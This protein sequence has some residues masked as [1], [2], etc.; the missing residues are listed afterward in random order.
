MLSDADTEIMAS[1]VTASVSNRIPRVATLLQWIMLAAVSLLTMAEIDRLISDAIGPDRQSHSL[2]SVIGPLAIFNVPAWG[3]W[4]SSGLGSTIGWWIVASALIDAL[5]VLAYA[6]ILFRLTARALPPNPP[7]GSPPPLEWVNVSRVLLWSLIATEI[8]EAGFLLFGASVILGLPFPLDVVGGMVAVVSTLKWIVVA[9]FSAAVL[10]NSGTRTILARII[11]HSA[12]AVWVHRLSAVLVLVLVVFSCIPGAGVLDQLPDIQRQWLDSLSGLWYVAVAAAFLGIAAFGSFVLGRQRARCSFDIR[13]RQ[14]EDTAKL[15]FAR[16]W[17]WWLIPVM[18]WAA[19]AVWT[20][21]STV[22]LGGGWSQVPHH[23]GVAAVLFLLVPVMIVLLS[24]WLDGRRDLLSRRTDPDNERA[25]YSWIFGDVLAVLV[26]CVGGLGLVR[27][28]AGFIFLGPFSGLPLLQFVLGVAGFV[29]GVAGAILWP[30]ALVTANSASQTDDATAFWQR[31]TDWPRRHINRTRSYNPVANRSPEE[32]AR[33][34]V[35]LFWLLV[36]GAAVVTAALIF[37]TDFA[38]ALGGVAVTV[39]LIT[40]WGLILGSFTIALQDYRLLAIFRMFRLRAAPVLTLAIVV[41]LVFTVVTASG[42]GDATV[43]ATRLINDAGGTSDTNST[44][45]TNL[46][47]ILRERIT[48]SSC[49]VKTSEGVIVKPIVVVAAQG[50]GIRAAY[51]TSKAMSSLWATKESCLPESVLLSSGVSG[52]SLGLALTKAYKSQAAEKVELLASPSIVASAATGLLAGDLVATGFG[53]H[54]PSM[55]GGDYKWRDRAALIEEGWIKAAKELGKPLD[56]KPTDGTGYLVLNSTDARSKCR[57]LVGQLPASAPNPKQNQSD[58]LSCSSPTIAPAKSGNLA[59]IYGAACPKSLD[60]AAAAMLSAR[61]PFITPAGRFPSGDSSCAKGTA[62]Q[63]ID[64]GY[65][66]GSALGTVADLAPTIAEAVRSYNSTVG[67]AEGHYAV[68]ILLYLRNSSGFDL[69]PK[70]AGAVAE[71]LIPFI[72]YGARSNQVDEQAW[73]QRI[74][75]SFQR[76]CP[77]TGA[78]GCGNANKNH[79][80]RSKII[81]VAPFTKPTIVPPLGWALSKV[82]ATSLTDAVKDATTDDSS[83]YAHLSELTSLEQQ[84]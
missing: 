12:R 40:A 66:E 78:T 83:A 16:Q 19:L 76:Y 26:L 31:W 45:E 28:F 5:F 22:F 21:L 9:V 61:F 25:V 52:G 41:P 64:G 33:T 54:S 72:G 18:A 44:P 82:S 51:L 24:R 84:K 49:L 69:A 4:A 20:V 3:Q 80:M 36:V 23:F 81:V 57:V 71:P 32:A 34:R 63:L 58:P 56:L 13:V 47:A 46:A 65:A 30:R 8:L 75:T 7:A 1:A 39:V 79:L 62:T 11:K 43:H 50:G 48:A 70:G 29:L 60:W 10:R 15:P 2:T 59:T 17:I 37:P 73:V 35:A 14:V 6:V 68:P 38:R 42:G 67:A 55:V 53:V 74:M 77:A 27:S